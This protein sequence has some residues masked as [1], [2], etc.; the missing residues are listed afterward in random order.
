VILRGTARA[1]IVLLRR[2]LGLLAAVFER[3]PFAM[4]LASKFVMT[5]VAR[6]DELRHDW[7]VARHCRLCVNQLGA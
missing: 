2:E 5:L 6:S 3:L 4:T 1:V 7:I